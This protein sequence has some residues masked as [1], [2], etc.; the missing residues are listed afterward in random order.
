MPL[1]TQVP[2]PVAPAHLPLVSQQAPQGLVGT[3][4]DPAKAARA[5]FVC[6]TTSQLAK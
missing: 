5:D 6:S 2:A 1:P 3:Y 4:K